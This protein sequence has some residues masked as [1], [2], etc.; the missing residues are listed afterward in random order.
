MSLYNCLKTFNLSSFGLHRRQTVEKKKTTHKHTHSL[1]QM[2]LA[3]EISDGQKQVVFSPEL[4]RANTVSSQHPGE[5]HCR[6]KLNT[7][8]YTSS[9]YSSSSLN[10]MCCPLLLLSILH[11]SA[12]ARQ[13][14]AFKFFLLS[15]C[16]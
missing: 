12:Q 16:T 9:I 4:S 2:P 6:H 3:A 7:A 1:L 10:I 8:L 15:F 14:L 11:L 5:L 13:L